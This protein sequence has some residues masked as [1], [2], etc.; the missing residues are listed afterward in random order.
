MDEIVKIL[1]APMRKDEKW[2][3]Y[4]VQMRDKHGNIYDAYLTPEEYRLRVIKA[5]L[6]GTILITE[7]LLEEFEKAVRDVV[8]RD[9]IDNN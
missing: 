4:K 7:R 5:K 6:L 9:Q 1:H 2:E 8:R 3:L